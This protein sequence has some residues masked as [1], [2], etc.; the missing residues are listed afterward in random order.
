MCL[1]HLTGAE[2]LTVILAADESGHEG[3]W[4][5]QKWNPYWQAV[6]SVLT[7]CAGA[8]YSSGTTGSCSDGVR[9]YHDFYN[10]TTLSTN[11]RTHKYLQGVGNL[12]V[13]RVTTKVLGEEPATLTCDSATVITLRQRPERREA[14]SST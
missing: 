2:E 14:Q 13:P 3:G 1:P 9:G 6:L 10:P 8:T 11:F 4:Q 12:P 7:A 5:G